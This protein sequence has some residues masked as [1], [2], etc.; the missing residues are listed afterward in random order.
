MR[1]ECFVAII[2]KYY[3]IGGTCNGSDINF[4]FVWK[5][6]TFTGARQLHLLHVTHDDVRECVSRVRSRAILPHIR[7]RL[8]WILM[9]GADGVRFNLK[10]YLINVYIYIMI[11]TYSSLANIV[12]AANPARCVPWH[13]KNR[14]A[15]WIKIDAAR[16]CA[17]VPQ[18]AS[19]IYVFF[20]FW[21]P[22]IV[23]TSTVVR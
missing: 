21:R 3:C 17:S 18:P 22:F 2:T 19:F 10:F 15:A 8:K 20:F 13:A 7:I 12:N 4:D 16:P 5:G 9:L 6:V 14:M 23:L 11:A 1:E